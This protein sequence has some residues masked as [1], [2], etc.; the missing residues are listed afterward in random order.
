MS[1]FPIAYSLFLIF[2][3]FVQYGMIQKISAL[4]N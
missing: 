3:A 2:H 1:T 4:K